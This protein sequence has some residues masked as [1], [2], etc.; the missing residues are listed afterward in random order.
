LFVL[1]NAHII[2]VCVTAVSKSHKFLLK[3]RQLSS[4]FTTTTPTPS[5]RR[6]VIFSARNS[7]STTS[8]RFF[9]RRRT[10]TR[11]NGQKRRGEVFEVFPNLIALGTKTRRVRV[12]IFG[13]V[14]E[15]QTLYSN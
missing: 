5:R 3:V 15:Y 14:G 10:L 4:F 12:L 1:Y 2:S 8:R 6:V 13:N 9:Q 7:T 11:R